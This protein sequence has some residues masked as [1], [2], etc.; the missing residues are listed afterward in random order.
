LPDRIQKWEDDDGSMPSIEEKEGGSY[1]SLKAAP[2]LPKSGE[3][4]VSSC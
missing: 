2:L 4:R 1:D 3:R